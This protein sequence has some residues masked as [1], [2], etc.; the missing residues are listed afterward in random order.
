VPITPVCTLLFCTVCAMC[1]CVCCVYC[2]LCILVDCVL[3]VPCTLYVYCVLYCHQFFFM[4]SA[5]SA[6]AD[7]ELLPTPCPHLV[8]QHR[9]PPPRPSAREPVLP[10]IVISPLKSPRSSTTSPRLGSPRANSPRKSLSTPALPPVVVANAD[11]AAPN[12]LMSAEPAPRAASTTPDAVSP[13]QV[14]RKTG[15]SIS[16]SCQSCFHRI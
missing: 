5:F 9:P 16:G 13:R 11:H 6:L 14:R 7:K 10:G 1:V 2:V 12:T 4:F 8:H 15:N 3:C